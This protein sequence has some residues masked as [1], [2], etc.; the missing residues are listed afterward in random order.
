M[1]TLGTKI[2]P[3]LL[4]VYIYL[5]YPSYAMNK[6]LGGMNII[7]YYIISDLKVDVI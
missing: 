1:Y 4:F 7:L 2:I 5:V 3:V 6:I